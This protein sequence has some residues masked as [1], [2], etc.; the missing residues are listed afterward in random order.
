MIGN[1]AYYGLP[2]PTSA[3]IGGWT[4]QLLEFYEQGNLIRNCLA[5]TTSAQLRAAR[6]QMSS[7]PVPIFECP[8]DPNVAKGWFYAAGGM[9]FRLT[10]YLAVNGNDE[11]P[12]LYFGHTQTGRNARNGIFPKMSHAA[13]VAKPI[14]RMTDVTDGLSNTIAFGERPVVV[15]AESFSVWS[16]TDWA[17][18]LATPSRNEIDYGGCTLPSYYKLG[19]IH[20]F[21]SLSHFWSLHPGGANWG[22]ADGSVRFIRY[23]VEQSILPALASRNGGEVVSLD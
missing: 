20:E 14:V 21:C 7:L 19:N 9:T 2:P 1:G 16:S 22:F 5:A 4:T 8:S 13:T 23:S 3:T 18:M 11:W 10:D 15:G 17:T 12:E 6:D